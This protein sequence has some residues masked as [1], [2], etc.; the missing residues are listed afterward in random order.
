MRILI[1]TTK[2]ENIV[3]FD[4]Q[5][6]LA[7][8]IHKWL[9]LNELHDKISLYSFSWLSG[10]TLCKFGFNF[11]KG[12]QWFI[13]FHE[14]EY[15]KTIIKSILSSPEMFCGMKVT[16]VTI[17]DNPDFTSTEDFV[18]ASPIFLKERCENKV[19][20]LTYNDESV[21]E[22][23]EYSIRHKITIANI[24]EDDTLKISIGINSGMCKTKI[25]KI[26]DISNK[27]FYCPIHITAKNETKQFIWDVGLGH[28]TG[29]GFGSIY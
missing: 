28:S 29:V 13:S 11:E 20:H 25:V 18:L 26:H 16:D 10:A 22:L 1:Y 9:G 21:D 2:N 23:L 14:R 6:L 4:Y 24:P 5:G 12:S 8:T 15:L 7:G 17:K 27:C 3:P 19:K